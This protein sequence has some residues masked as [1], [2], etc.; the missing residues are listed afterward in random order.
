MIE[1]EVAYLQSL[2]RDFEVVHYMANE[3]A[4]TV[5]S[6]V[7]NLSPDAAASEIVTQANLTGRLRSKDAASSTMGSSLC[8]RS[9]RTATRIDTCAS[10]LS[11]D[12]DEDRSYSPS[13]S[14]L[15]GPITKR[16][17]NSKEPAL[18]TACNGMS[19]RC[20]EDLWNKPSIEILMR[21]QKNYD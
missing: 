7:L 13:K 14:E 9:K 6:L 11:M 1:S 19:A 4:D 21:I 20:S 17:R 15:D 3:R 10:S 18:N 16:P 8:T 2:N 12:S 5:E